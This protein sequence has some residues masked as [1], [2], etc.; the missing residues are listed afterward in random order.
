[1][2]VNLKGETKGM[3]RMEENTNIATS[4]LLIVSREINIVRQ[5]AENVSEYFHSVLITSNDY[6][7]EIPL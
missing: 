6:G 3:G 5:L 2:L 4:V 1:M 7:F